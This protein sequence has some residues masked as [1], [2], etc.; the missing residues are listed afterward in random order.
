MKPDVYNRE[1]PSQRILA[2]IG[3]KW[4]MLILCSL[5]AGPRRTHELKRRLAGV[6]S[7]MLTQTLRELERHGIVYRK[8]HGEVP[9]RVEYGLTALGRS[10]AALVVEIESW[11]TTNYT[12]INGHA[13]QYDAGV[14]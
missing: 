9:P 12:R 8:D 6:S 4:S 2:L 7:K 5:R 10:L 14:A 3:G 13:R 11:V 1:C